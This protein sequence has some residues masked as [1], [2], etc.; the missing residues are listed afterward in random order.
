MKT[1]WIVCMFVSVSFADNAKELKV[2]DAEYMENI[3]ESKAYM[4]AVEESFSKKVERK[5]EGEKYEND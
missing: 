1:L 3:K 5:D 2:A 4:Q